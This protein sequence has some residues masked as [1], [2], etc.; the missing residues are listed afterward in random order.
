MYVWH[1]NEHKWSFNV[2]K[3]FYLCYLYT[4]LHCLLEGQCA[5]L[6]LGVGDGAAWTTGGW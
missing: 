2:L 6:C 5:P 4:Q 1:E 3:I